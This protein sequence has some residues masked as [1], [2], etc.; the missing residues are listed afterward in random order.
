MDRRT[1]NRLIGALGAVV[2]AALIVT[3]VGVAMALTNRHSDSAATLASVSSPTPHRT[4][5]PD[6]QAAVDSDAHNRAAALLNPP[7]PGATK[8]EIIV[9][10]TDPPLPLGIFKAVDSQIK[11]FIFETVWRDLVDGNY[12]TVWTGAT[13]GDPT[14]GVILV[15]IMRPDRGVLPGG[16]YEAPLN[17]GTLTIVGANGH[18]LSLSSEN[19]GAFVFDADARTLW[20]SNGNP[21]PTDSPTPVP[22]KP[23][24]DVGTPWPEGATTSPPPLPASQPFAIPTHAPIREN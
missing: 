20:Y 21:V 18:L 11:G 22:P 13:I 12:L 5:P 10:Q 1:E 4:L 2:V 15:W 16:Y 9:A 17:S 8:D 7:S 3:T 6:K 23:T 24:Y 14:R 19:A